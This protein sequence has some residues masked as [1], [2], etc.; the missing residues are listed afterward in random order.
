MKKILFAT[1][2]KGIYFLRFNSAFVILFNR[3]VFAII[4]FFLVYSE[5]YV[6]ID[7]SNDIGAKANA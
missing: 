5:I 2:I 3:I 4:F 6:S 7:C 1:Y